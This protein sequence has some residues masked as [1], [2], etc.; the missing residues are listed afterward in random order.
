MGTSCEFRTT[1]TPTRYT[2]G[3]VY[4]R[5]PELGRLP[6][7]DHGM[8]ARCGS[9]ARGQQYRGPGRATHADW[10]LLYSYQLGDF[11]TVVRGPRLLVQRSSAFRLFSNCGSRAG[12]ELEDP[13]KSGFHTLKK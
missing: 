13:S 5:L 7:R 8:C 1:P 4:Q 6:K 12:S 3:G 9:E 2:S 11:R 10:R